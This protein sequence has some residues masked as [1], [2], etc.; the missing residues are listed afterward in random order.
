MCA[1]RHSSIVRQLLVGL[2]VR[3]VAANHDTSVIMIERTYSRHIGD[4]AMRWCVR[5][6]W[7]Q[8][9][10]QRRTTEDRLGFAHRV[11]ATYLGCTKARR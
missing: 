11:D 3:V 2:P 5:R 4:H 6:C 8:A 7:T 1:L 9:S 10:K